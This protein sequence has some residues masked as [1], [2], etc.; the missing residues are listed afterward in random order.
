MPK[1]DSAPTDGSPGES[2]PTVWVTHTKTEA[3]ELLGA[4]QEWSREARDATVGW[5]T[6]VADADGNELTVAIE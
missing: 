6:H 3:W 1:M 4:L 2:L 5:H